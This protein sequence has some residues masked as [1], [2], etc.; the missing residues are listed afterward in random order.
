MEFTAMEFTVNVNKSLFMINE[1]LVKKEEV[2]RNDDDNR[3]S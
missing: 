1:K 2:L 3:S